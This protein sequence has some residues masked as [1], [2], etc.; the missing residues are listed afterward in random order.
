[1][2]K[3]PI[4]VSL[5]VPDLE[6]ARQWYAGVLGQAPVF[7]APFAVAFAAGTGTL[8]LLPLESTEQTD[9]RSV[10]FF[11]VD[12]IEDSYRQ[13]VGAGASARSEITFT[14][15][16]SRMAKVVDPF[17]NVLGIMSTAEKAKPVDSR[18]S[19]SAMTVA[20][21]RALAAHDDRERMRGPDYLAEVFLNEEGKKALGDRVG[22]EWILRKMVGSH[23]YFL[24]RTLYL[25]GI[26]D[27]ALRES[28]PQLVFLGAGYDSRPYRFKELIGNTR[29]FELDVEPTQRRKRVLLERA[30]VSIPARLVYVTINFETDAIGDTLARAGFDRN[31]ETV[32]LWE[33]VTYYLTAEAV[34]QT[35]EAVRSLEAP[36]SAIC[37]D[38]MVHRPRP[39]GAREGAG[40]SPWQG[41]TEAIPLA[42]MVPWCP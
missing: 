4:L 34:D 32:F 28:I 17:G 23:E 42:A 40:G 10:P 7:E 5:H 35:L 19:E 11:E 14:M 27:R 2:L 20:F 24:A 36:G 15:L 12:D 37:F 31:Q 18:P 13:L 33:G 30:G 29:I 21:S 6:K 3:N 39:L 9:E 22:R 41:R 16:R 1:M 8:L 38:Y 25:D 26:V